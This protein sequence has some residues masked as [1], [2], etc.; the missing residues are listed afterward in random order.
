[1]AT[2]N[3]ILLH[4]HSAL[5]WLLV[6]LALGAL[7]L[8][9]LGWLGSRPYDKLTTNAM[10]ALGILFTA[11]WVIGLVQLIVRGISTATWL[12]QWFEHLFVM[13]IAV[14]V[15][16]MGRRRW[17][18]AD[19]QTR[20]RN[21]FIVVVVAMVLVYAGVWLLGGARWDMIPGA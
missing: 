7:L 11:Q 1:M 10:K 16:E 14:G 4:T 6:L 21:E 13:T 8:L 19:S 12:R 5:R 17:K 9:A 3:L 20:A 15:I 18:D 2:V